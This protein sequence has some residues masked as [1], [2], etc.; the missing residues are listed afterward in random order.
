VLN[1]IYTLAGRHGERGSRRA[2]H[3][4]SDN[5]EGMLTE[6]NGSQ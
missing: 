4:E 5:Y 1:E 2:L 6:Q 3:E